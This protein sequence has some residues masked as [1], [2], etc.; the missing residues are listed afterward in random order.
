MF[1]RG[2]NQ[3]GS[4]DTDD[5]YHMAVCYINAEDVAEESA[6]SDS[7]HH[8]EPESRKL[9]LTEIM[10]QI[11]DHV[12]HW[13]ELLDMEKNRLCYQTT[14]GLVH[15]SVDLYN[16][17]YNKLKCLLESPKVYRCVIWSAYWAA[18]RCRN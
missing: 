3:L 4:E 11:N 9:A 1:G 6:T 5:V 14:N 12:V 17:D 2:G 8:G 10:K 7:K 15:G 13:M 18:S 16:D